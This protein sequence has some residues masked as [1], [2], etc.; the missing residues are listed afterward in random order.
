MVISMKKYIIPF[1]SIIKFIISFVLL[2]FVILDIMQWNT[3]IVAIILSIIIVFLILYGIKIII[4]KSDSIF[5]SS[6]LLIGWYKVQ[7]KENISFENIEFIEIKHRDYMYSSRGKEKTGRGIESRISGHHFIEFIYGDGS[8]KRIF[9]ND[10]SDKQITKI[11]EF[12]KNKNIKVKGN[13][14]L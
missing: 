13:N 3:F 9:C 2:I 12:C 11:L 7:Y 14:D 8:I 5:V 1:G 10:L 4:I 6:D